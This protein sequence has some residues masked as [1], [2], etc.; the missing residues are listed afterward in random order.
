MKPVPEF[1]VC[2]HCGQPL[3]AHAHWSV[4]INETLRSMCCPGCQAVAVAIVDSG[5][6]D[7]YSDR[8][9]YSGSGSNSAMPDQVQLLAQ[10]AA[11][12]NTGET[13]S[14]AAGTASETLFSI[15]GIHCPACVWLIERR[16]SD[17]P[18][19][20]SANLNVANEKLQVCWTAGQSRPGSVVRAL[21]VI[22][23][24]ARPYTVLAHGDM[25]RRQGKQLFRQLFIAGLAMMQVMMYAF[26]GYVSP[27]DAID[28]DH[29]ALM[30]WASLLLTLPAVCYS[31]LPFFKGAWFSLRNRS[32]GMDVPI[33]L[34]II[35]TFSASAAA[36]I[37]GKGEVYFDSVTMF[38]FL[39]LCS[40][41]LELTARRKTFDS[42]EKMQQALP[43]TALRLPDYPSSIKEE[44]VAASRLQPGDI[45]L[46]RAGDTIAADSTIVE[47]HTSIDASLL[48]GESRLVQKTA[49]DELPGGAVNAGQA[50]VAKIVRRA[51][52]SRLSELIRLSE[53]A[54]AGKPHMVSWID[55][56]AS[57]FVA[58]QLL[59]AFV[60]FCIW[61]Y[62]APAEAWI[63]AVSVL[64]VSCPCALSLAT[65]AA[66][67]SAGSRLL[68]QGVLVMQANILET[69]TSVTH[70]VFD[71]TGT[72]TM[73]RASLQHIETYG[74]MTDAQCLQLAA[75][76]ETASSHPLASALK[77][78]AEQ[79][80]PPQPQ[81]MSVDEHSIAVSYIH[82]EPG[83]GLQ[84]NK[85][86]IR[87]RL[88]SRQFIT[89]M[90][91][92][93]I[94]LQAEALS[95]SVHLASELEYLARF[96]L[97][98]T[99]RDDA[100]ETVRQ[101]QLAGKEVIL[102]SGDDEHI[103]QK[104]AAELGIKEA[105]GNHLP[106]QKLQLV[107]KLQTYGAVVAMVGDG[108]NDAAVLR[109]ADV[110]FAMGSGSSLAQISADAVLMPEHTGSLSSLYSTFML[111]QQ[112][113]SVIRQ[114]LI[115]ACGYNLLAIPAA[116]CGY[117]NPLLS[118]AGMALSSM[119]VVLNALRLRGIP[120]QAQHARH[121]AQQ[122]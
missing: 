18:G 120:S 33:A 105:Y 14:E 40:R 56:I 74:S 6:A 99:L 63:A 24:T 49:G 1:D 84:I 20:L 45:M 96:D 93:E 52:D 77:R 67:A 65:P 2:F 95:S 30:R 100:R 27:T 60:V 46:I 51:D 19:V 121:Q 61:R 38:I 4:R 79:L 28:A 35:V 90:L 88:G 87:Y 104:I 68:R 36:T 70:V 69:L 23:Y 47:G 106:E 62:I 76:M 5:C 81:S 7:Y 114:N 83:L 113:R 39:L 16:L 53:R 97:Q 43:A 111:A 115:W 71:K 94:P 73:G 13:A 3:P 72:L 42:L 29:A 10:N 109:A 98:D 89:Q 118:G 75:A 37:N 101:L 15:E 86:G 78:A 44:M 112:S 8:S 25:V 17:L 48:S 122:A 50:V 55:R 54:G 66:L 91:G 32:L 57:V 102:L 59:I 108:I 116:A 21:Q 11:A 64:V 34:A 26:P 103:V 58:L 92:W 82:T 31:A 110:S 85:D 119:V 12:I 107:Q 9:T 41:Y 22:G 80:L 117:V